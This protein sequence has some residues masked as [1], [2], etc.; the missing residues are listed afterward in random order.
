MQQE[1]NKKMLFIASCVALI[2]TAMSFAIRGNIMSDLETAFGLTQTQLGHIGGAAF[3]SFGLFIIFGGPLVDLL[4][5]GMLLRVAAACHIGGALMTIFAPSY[6]VLFLGTFIVGA[7]NGLV[8]A[9]CNPLIATAYPEDKAHKL[10]VFHA[11]FPGGIVIGGLLGY[12]LS[13][14]GSDFVLGES[15]PM[16][17]GIALWKIKVATLLIPAAIYFIMILPQKFPPTERAAAGV[18]FGEMF[19]EALKR[20]LF[21]IIFLMMWFTASTELV[22]GGWINKV[23][24]DLMSDVT[25]AGI[26]FLVWGTGMMWFLRQFCSR[27]AHSISPILLIAVTAPF[28]AVGLAMFPF[29]GESKALFFVAA[30]LLFFG[31]CFWWPTMLAITSE[32]CA[33]TGALGLAIIGG[34]GSFSTA[35][36]NPVFGYIKGAI[37]ESVGSESIG[38]VKTLQVWAILPVILCV[39]F[40]AVYLK[41]QASGGYK[42]EHLTAE[43]GEDA[44]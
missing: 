7:G 6:A 11:W 8:E 26:L 20:P 13:T 16:L 19:T 37:T 43:N 10:T 23:Y 41:D 40:V 36:G 27:I 34:A 21:W 17:M 39:V 12:W 31:V 32:R 28:A 35:A 3:W 5:M 29:V 42:A 38:A 44:E 14:R 30:S 2:A 15:I 1:V 18:P 25:G 4:G 9:V 22:P 24:D 33:K